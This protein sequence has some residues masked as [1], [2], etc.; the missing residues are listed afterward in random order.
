MHVHVALVTVF[1]SQ[2]CYKGKGYILYQNHKLNLWCA[3]AC[4]TLITEILITVHNVCHCDLSNLPCLS[5][6]S[7]LPYMLW[8]WVVLAPGLLHTST[9]HFT[10]ALRLSWSARGQRHSIFI[11]YYKY[12]HFNLVGPS[13]Q[14]Y[15]YKLMCNAVTLVWGSLRLS[16]VPR[17]GTRLTQAHPN[18]RQKQSKTQYML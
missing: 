6:Y 12:T 7:K 4:T 1:V 3:Q 8:I 9:L 17:L 18:N 2:S 13:K 16:L 5:W 15:T 14:T 10:L 11:K